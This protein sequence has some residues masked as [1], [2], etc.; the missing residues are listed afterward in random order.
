VG[1][2]QY[3]VQSSRPELANAV[4]ALGKYLNKYTHE[5]Y[6]MAK[7]VLRYLRGFSDYGLMW[8]KKE[9]PDLHF[10]AYADADLGNEKYD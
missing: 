10:V 7:R 2:L 8:E 4:R 6:S 3:L 9:T 5:K 1:C